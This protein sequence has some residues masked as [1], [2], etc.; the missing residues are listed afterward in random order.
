MSAAAES[1]SGPRGEHAAQRIPPDWALALAVGL[2]GGLALLLL[3][4]AVGHEPRPRGDDLIYELMARDPFGVHTFPFGFRIGLPLAVHVLPLTTTSAFRLLTWTAAAGAASFAYLLMRALG[5]RRELASALAVLMCISPPFL[6]VAIRG[7]RNTDVATVLFLLAAT[8]FAVHRND[9]ALAAT[10]L[11]GVLVREA[12]LFEIPLAYALWCERALDVRA[13]VR[14]VAVG[15]PAAGA[16]LALRLGLMTVGEAQVPGYGGSLLGG[17]WT[18]PRM[19]LEHPLQE[20]RRLFTVYGPLWLIA[21]LALRDMRFARRGLVLVGLSV[22]AMSYA[23]DWGRM[24]LL[25][26]PLFYPA[27][28]HV[29][30]QHPR[31]R[32][33]VLGASLALALGYALYMDHGGLQTIIQTRAPRYPVR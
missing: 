21:P 29:L 22:L 32:L 26:A 31:W 24:I 5:A 15:A 4:S 18:I 9:L 19:G 25:A 10:L 2:L 11:V 3:S 1:V 23:T 7:G 6:L 30:E 13:L 28:A 20:A 16:Y 14:T 27:G 17:R 12:V 8:Y 33:P